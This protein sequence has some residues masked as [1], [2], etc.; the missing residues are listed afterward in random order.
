MLSRATTKLAADTGLTCNHNSR[1]AHS[2]WQIQTLQGS[3][4]QGGHIAGCLWRSDTAQA[5]VV[6]NGQAL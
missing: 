3:S 6:S 5:R 1:Q 2:G 4:Q